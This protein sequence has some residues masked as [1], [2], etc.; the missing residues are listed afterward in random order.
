[1]TARDA[2]GVTLVRRGPATATLGMIAVAHL[3]SCSATHRDDPTPL[4]PPRLDQVQ[5]L[6]THNSYHVA[7]PVGLYSAIDDRA[8][9]WGYTHPPLPEQLDRGMRALELDVYVDDDA[10]FATPIGPIPDATRP[11]MAEP[12]L[13]VF[14]VPD[15][16]Q[17]STCASLRGCLADIASWSAAHP[18]HLPIFVMLECVA[19]DVG[20][21]GVLH[22]TKPSAWGDRH[23]EQLEATLDS[24]LGPE[25][26]VTPDFIRGEAASVAEALRTSG[27]PSLES[28]RGK[29]MV[30]ITND[31]AV[32]QR[33]LARRPGLRDSPCFVEVE[34]DSPECAVL[35][36]NDPIG[37]RDI[38]QQARA[39]HVLVRTRADANLEEVRSGDTRRRDAA[40]SGGANVIS[41]DALAVLRDPG[42]GYAVGFPGGATARV[43]PGSGRPDAG[44]PLAP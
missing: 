21:R 5:W 38:I 22:F 11:A 36:L 10:R 29:V 16:D 1:M 37:Q 19:H 39:R 9:A 28:L 7:P 33:Q 4:P 15:L 6:G 20:T 32:I 30:V 23:L 14:H 12:G 26:L 43:H 3:V 17:G 25:R 27:W 34:A 24:V 42:N 13:K 44:Q 35:V 8:V 31:H 18:R 41:S 40:L 2:R